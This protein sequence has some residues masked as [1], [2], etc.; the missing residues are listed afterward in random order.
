LI[1]HRTS[2]PTPQEKVQRHTQYISTFTYEPQHRSVKSYQ[3]RIALQLIRLFRLFLLTVGNLLCLVMLCLIS[4]RRDKVCPQYRVRNWS[5]TNTL[6]QPHTL[7]GPLGNNCTISPNFFW[8]K[9]MKFWLSN[10]KNTGNNT[11]NTL[12][13]WISSCPRVVLRCR[14]PRL[15]LFRAPGVH[16]PFALLLKWA[17]PALNTAK[18]AS[19]LLDKHAF[20]CAITDDKYY[21]SPKS[22]FLW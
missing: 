3:A 5:H 8:A 14:K 17:W 15:K 16:R 4:A 21:W 20:K 11:T 18:K 13:T 2:Q 6:Q 22:F 12:Q 1:R 9:M 7:Y 10:T 19:F